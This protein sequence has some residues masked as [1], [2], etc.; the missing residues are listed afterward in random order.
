MNSF[1]ALAFGAAVSA[2]LIGGASAD[3]FSPP[4]A[5]LGRGYVNTTNATPSAS[6]FAACATE[7]MNA[8]SLTTTLP[9]STSLN[10]SGGCL[11]IVSPNNSST[12]TPNA[13]DKINGGTTGASVTLPSGS[14]AVVT[15]DGNGNIFYATSAASGGTPGGSN[16]QVEYNS[17]GS[18]GGVSGATSNG[19]TITF[20]TSDLIMKGSST[21]TTTFASANAGASNFTLTFPAITDT[22]VTLGANQTFGGADTFSGGVTMS[23]ALTYGGVT[24][25]NSVTG[26]GSMVLSSAPTLAGATLSAALTY[27]GVT[28]SNSVTGTGSMVLA[29]SPTLVTPAIGVA[30]GTSLALNGCTIGSNSYC[31]AG[32][33]TESGNG[34]ASTA[35]VAYT[36]NIFTGGTGTTTFPFIFIEPNAPTAATNWSTSGTLL[37]LESGSGFSGNVI[38]YKANGNT[39]NFTVS[40]TG[41]VTDTNSFVTGSASAYSFSTRSKTTS[42]ADGIIDMQN[43]AA[44]SF[45]RLDFGGTTSSFMA[46]G[47]SGTTIALVAGDGTTPTY[48]SCTGFTSNASGVLACTASDERLKNKQGAIDSGLEI[49][50]K[51]PSGR[52]FQYHDNKAL[53]WKAPD[54]R[55]HIG[56]YAQDVCK[57]DPRLCV[58]QSHGVKNYEDRGLLSVLVRAV[59]EEDQEN[60]LL[61]RELAVDNARLAR[62]EKGLRK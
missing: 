4:G 47:I 38:D 34:A 24:L 23:A 55:Q 20:A 1:R 11:V 31:D 22:V 16:T 62:L 28:L 44:T 10:P 7:T 36:G 60:W 25:S 37:G 3:V 45:T 13:A 48:A 18:F 56:L 21:G 9:V 43:N 26:T 50:R 57:A 40:A 39:S 19:T 29:T 53:S 49:L 61:Q 41:T 59:Q 17:S 15:T 33:E 14:T 52:L 8:G 30:T 27:G 58:T 2:L 46:L 35:V 12:L 5:P 42:P 32:V 54:D 51:I 6:D